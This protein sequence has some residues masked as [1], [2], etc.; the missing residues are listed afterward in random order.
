MGSILLG[1]GDA[2]GEFET[3]TDFSLALLQVDLSLPG[4]YVINYCILSL[5]GS[6]HLGKSSESVQ[7]AITGPFL[8][9]RHRPSA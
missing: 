2:P 6:I 1:A 7:C 5:V 3:A 9:M 8:R 4:L